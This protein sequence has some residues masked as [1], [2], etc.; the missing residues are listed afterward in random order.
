[1]GGLLASA[2]GGAYI[3]HLGLMQTP[4]NSTPCRT[5]RPKARCGG[6]HAFGTGILVDTAA[7]N[8]NKAARVPR[9]RKISH[10]R[11]L[12]GISQHLTSD[13]EGCPSG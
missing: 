7:A 11:E 5:I 1:M 8:L 10:I 4:P 2:H 12:I 9:G 3:A 13:T 6:V